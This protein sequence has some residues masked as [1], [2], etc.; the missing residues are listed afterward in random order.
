MNAIALLLLVALATGCSARV[1]D[2]PSASP[3]AGCEITG[4]HW[5]SSTGT[6]DKD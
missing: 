3:R 5:R 2:E 6:C 4:G 1:R